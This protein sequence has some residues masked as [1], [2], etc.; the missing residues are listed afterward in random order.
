MKFRNA[1]L[2]VFLVLLIDQALKFYVKLNFYYQGEI[3]VIGTWFKLF[4]I[5]NSGM[6]F[7]MNF[8]GHWG[9]LALTLFRLI[10]VIWGFYFIKNTLVKER[11]TRGLIACSSLILAGAM[12]NLIDSMIYGKIFTTSVSV[13]KAKLVPWGQGYGEL[14]HGKVVDMLYFPLFQFQWPDWVPLVG[15]DF[16]EFFKPIFN[17]AD[18]SIFIGVVLIL[19]FQKRFIQT[20]SKTNT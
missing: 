12:G 8:G 4:F 14:F 15:G 6:A 17:V 9:K 18:A 13:H 20:K 2:I 5:E 1:V 16:F 7:G 10:A 11:Y 19:L 3:N